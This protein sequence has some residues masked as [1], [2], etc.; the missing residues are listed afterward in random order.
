[1]TKQRELV[2]RI[3]RNS[4]DH[5]TAEQIFFAAKSEMPSIVLATV[6]NN[7]KAL[8]DA[9][10]IRRITLDGAADRYD[11]SYTLH[12]HMVCDK[13]GKITDIDVPDSETE[14]QTK[15]GAL[16]VRIKRK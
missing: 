6:Y 1:M 8:C 15:Y 3:I 13:C 2:L 14:I 12:E 10:E 16:K 7:L 5:L 9:G 4:K 11:K